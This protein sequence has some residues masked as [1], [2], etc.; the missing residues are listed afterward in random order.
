[1]VPRGWEG[2]CHGARSGMERMERARRWR[3]PSLLGMENR[4]QLACLHSNHEQAM[5]WGQ[6][7]LLEGETLVPLHSFLLQ[8]FSA[9]SIQAESVTLGWGLVKI[10]AQESLL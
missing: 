2:P 9:F 3:A 5:S 1:M 6:R 10:W 4:H 7:E 8:S